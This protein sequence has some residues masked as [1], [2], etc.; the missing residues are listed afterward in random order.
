MSQTR[1]L[2]AIFSTVSPLSESAAYCG[3]GMTVLGPK[4]APRAAPCNQDRRDE[5]C[6]CPTEEDA[7]A[8]RSKAQPVQPLATRP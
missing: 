3:M 6:G 5:Q 4:P 1:S 7:T 8:E 2:A